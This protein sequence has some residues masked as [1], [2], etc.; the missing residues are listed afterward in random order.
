MKAPCL[1]CSYRYEHCHSTCVAYKSFTKR[2][3]QLSEDR[4][5]KGEFENYLM[6]ARENMKNRKGVM[7]L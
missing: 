5:K 6:H 7:R 2:R 1:K 3:E 4:V